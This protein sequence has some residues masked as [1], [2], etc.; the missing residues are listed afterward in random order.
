MQIHGIT[1]IL[2]FNPSDFRRFAGI[3]V[4]D[5]TTVVSSPGRIG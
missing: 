4:F 2:T 5:P 3:E 1:S